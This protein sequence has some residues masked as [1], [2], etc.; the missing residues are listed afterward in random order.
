[1]QNIEKEYKNIVTRIG[2][3]L[4]LFLVLFWGLT[5]TASNLGELLLKLF[6]RSDAAYI[7]SDLMSSF[8]YLFSFILPVPFF[9]LISKGQKSHF[10][11]LGLT[12]PEPRPVQSYT[13]VIFSGV[14]I[15]T[16]MA[17]V[18][19][20]AFPVIVDN[21]EMFLLDFSQPY[22]VV[23]AFIG[24][25]I[26]PAF[27]EELLFR[28]LIIS[29]L[30]PYGAGTAVIV[31]SV[32]FGLMHQNPV[33]LLYA[34]AA[35]LVF[36]YVYIKTESI[37][38]CVAV[39]FVNNFV[40]V[41]QMYFSSKFDEYYTAI[42]FFYVS[43]I[44]CVIGSICTVLLLRTRKNIEKENRQGSLFGR[45]DKISQHTAVARPFAIVIKNPAMIIFAVSC[46]TEIL[47]VSIAYMSGVGG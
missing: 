46:I 16:A 8:A 20:L 6:P 15:V 36:G 19:M 14:A 22:K 9:Y 27:A 1:M 7:I 30:K 39:H 47:L 2:I 37:W 21:T 12:M 31:S 3:T 32:L 29:N 40:S 13:A 35:G 5:G 18:N 10:L 23:L 43:L 33:Q 41:L 24:T 4:I 17:A 34:T 38:C 26:V 28:G 45:Y 11:A 42:L 25:A 44:L